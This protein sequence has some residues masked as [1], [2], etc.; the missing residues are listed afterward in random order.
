MPEYTHEITKLLQYADAELL[1]FILQLL[2][3]SITLTETHQQL[4]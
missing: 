1:D 3:K 2:Q 4:A